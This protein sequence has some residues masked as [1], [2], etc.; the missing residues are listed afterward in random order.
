M[1]ILAYS[2]CLG[3]VILLGGQPERVG[4]GIFII[5]SIAT[6]LVGGGFVQTST[7]D[8]LEFGVMAVDIGILLA[9]WAL[10]LSSARFWTYWVTGWQLIVVLVHL[11]MVLAANILP[12]AYGYASMYLSFPMVVLMMFASAS[13][14]LR[15]VEP[16]P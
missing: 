5:G 13:F 1:D 4:A 10:A 12:Y 2:A 3:L 9:L 11:Q 14:R 7:R 15:Q 6:A 16:T 8:A